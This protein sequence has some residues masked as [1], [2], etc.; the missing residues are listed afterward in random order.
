MLVEL[1]YFEGCPSWQEALE[2]LKTALAGDHLQA[3]IQ[4]VKVEDDAEAVRL[5]FLGSP[6]FRVNGEDL[7]PEERKR[8]N[9][10]C[11][12]YSTPQGMKGA[13]TIEMLREKLRTSVRP[14][15]YDQLPGS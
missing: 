8:Y 13:P 10:N 15:T 7:W 3:E 5:K 9:L 1:L 6:S 12:V 14:S 4:L 11:R 2:N